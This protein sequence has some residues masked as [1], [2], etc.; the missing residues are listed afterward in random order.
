MRCSPPMSGTRRGARCS[1]TNNSC[2]R[3]AACCGGRGWGRGGPSSSTAGAGV[4]PEGA[5]TPHPAFRAGHAGLVELWPPVEPE[6]P[7]EARPWE[8]PLEQRHARAPQA[9]L[10][11]AIAGTVRHWL[12]TGERLAARDR[13]VQAGDIMVLVR[14]LGPFVVEIV[15]ALQP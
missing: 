3:R 6:E 10:A 1:I 9:R 8:P 7:P 14:G 2:S 11:L 15:P 5:R 4:A 12:N 13:R